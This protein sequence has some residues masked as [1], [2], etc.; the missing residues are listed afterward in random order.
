MEEEY[1]DTGI[2]PGFP[3]GM[4]PAGG[5]TTLLGYQ[6]Q[7]RVAAA[8]AGFPLPPHA[9]AMIPAAMQH[10]MNLGLTHLNQASL[11]SGHYP[12]PPAFPGAQT[13]TKM[14]SSPSHTPIQSHPHPGKATTMSSAPTDMTSSLST[15]SNTKTISQSAQNM[16]THTQ[17]MLSPA[18]GSTMSTSP[19]LESTSTSFSPPKMDRSLSAKGICSPARAES[20]TSPTPSTSATVPAD[21]TSPKAND[22]A[23]T[24][25]SSPGTLT[26]SIDRLLQKE[27][28]PRKMAHQDSEDR[29][30]VTSDTTDFKGKLLRTNCTELINESS[31]LCVAFFLSC[32]FSM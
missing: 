29:G 22:E 9:A 26:Y 8:A 6:Q 15:T 19:Q 31:P 4:G 23:Q 17:S 12:G 27:D 3:G 14:G 1:N 10:Y 20:G 21:S 13:I 5:M 16:S 28:C 25:S 7:A 11:M 24:K 18:K 32:C 30:S 2:S